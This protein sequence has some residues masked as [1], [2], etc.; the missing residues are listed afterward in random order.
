MTMEWKGVMPA[1]TTCFDENLNIDH[2]FTAKHVNWLV[3]N[4]CTGIVTNGSL[5]EG[6]TFSMDEKI[7]LWKTVVG[8]VGDRVP[9]V[10]AIASMTTADA[11]EESG[12]RDIKDVFRNELDVSVL[13]GPTRFSIGADSSMRGARSIA[14][15][16]AGGR[17]RLP[18][19]FDSASTSTG[20][21][22]SSPAS[23]FISVDSNHFC[24]GCGLPASAPK[25]EP[26]C[27]ARPSRSR[28]CTPRLPTLASMS[29]LPHP[30]PPSSSTNRKSSSSS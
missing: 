15:H 4:G 18:I 9:V 13:S 2:D 30:V 20:R 8:A 22:G 10:A 7:A 12:A 29:V 11:I 1:I 23:R 26:R 19:L 17:V 6:G 25:S 16:S 24:D 14:R 21:A 5:G 28:T 27:S 3:D